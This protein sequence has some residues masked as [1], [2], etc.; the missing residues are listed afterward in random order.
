MEMISVIPV[1]PV[2]LAELAELT[3]SLGGRPNGSPGS[4]LVERGSATVYINSLTGDEPQ[5]SPTER[6]GLTISRSDGS[7]ELAFEI[8][9]AMLRRWGG[10]IDWSG[11]EFL[12]RW[13]MEWNSKKR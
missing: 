3:R 6:I 1:R 8:A 9:V 2:A 7:E 13:F 5:V 11:L 10:S 12:E 4:N